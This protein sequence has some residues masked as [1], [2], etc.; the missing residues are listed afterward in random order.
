MAYKM[1][2][3]PILRAPSTLRS[4][5]RHKQSVFGPRKGT[6]PKGIINVIKGIGGR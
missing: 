4:S 1:S 5:F 3:N 6:K 2:K